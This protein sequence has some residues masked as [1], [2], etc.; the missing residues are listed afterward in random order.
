[1]PQMTDIE[2]QALKTTIDK[3]SDPKFAE[4]FVTDWERGSSA[5]SVAASV[6][7]SEKQAGQLAT[8]LRRNGV[9][10][11]KMRVARVGKVKSLNVDR[12]KAIAETARKQQ[13]DKQAEGNGGKAHTRK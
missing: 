2:K 13:E 4:K 7:V 5:A 8:Y 11:K 1:M 3:L 6:G 9:A 12:L 10:L